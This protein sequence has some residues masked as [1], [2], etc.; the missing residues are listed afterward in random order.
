MERKVL[1]IETLLRNNKDNWR[2]V[3]QADPYNLKINESLG[4]ACISYDQINSDMNLPECQQSRGIIFDV[5]SLIP[6]CIPF[7]KFWNYGDTK[8]SKIDWATARIEQKID[9]SIIKVWFAERLNKWMISTNGCVDAFTAHLPENPTFDTFGDLV[10]YIFKT[11]YGS[12]MDFPWVK[13]NTYIFEVTSPYNRVVIPYKESDLTFLG[14]R[15]NYSLEETPSYNICVNIGCP[16]IPCPQTFDLQSAEQVIA[17]CEKYTGDQEGFVVVDKD[18]NRCKIKSSFY[19]HLHQSKNNGAINHERVIDMIQKGKL[20]EFVAYFD[21]DKDI[22]DFCTSVALTLNNYVQYMEEAKR[23]VD[24]MDKEGATRKAMAI[25]LVNSCA[26]V[27]WFGFTCLDRK[28]KLG[29]EI[30]SN[31]AWKEIMSMDASKVAKFITPE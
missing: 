5:D 18:F 25:A 13:A 15:N 2:E 16:L 19:V 9:G 6:V 3:V 21:G 14:S 1:E 29:I 22:S 24:K 30:M 23:M 26:S 11:N 17:E 20:D 7:Y 27:K 31:D 10:Q 4:Y 8:C 28:N 12:N